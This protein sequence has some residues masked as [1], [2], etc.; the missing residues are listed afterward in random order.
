MCVVSSS[1]T[2]RKYDFTLIGYDTG[3]SCLGNLVTE[4]VSKVY[5]NLF[6]TISWTPGDGPMKIPITLTCY[7][8][9]GPFWSLGSAWRHRGKT[10]TTVYDWHGHADITD[11]SRKNLSLFLEIK[12]KISG[13]KNSSQICYLSY[14]KSWWEPL[15]NSINIRIA[16]ILPQMYSNFGYFQ[17]PFVPFMC[18][19]ELNLESIK[20][21]K[22]NIS[23][24]A[25]SQ[26]RICAKCTLKG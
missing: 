24:P 4:S 8:I 10:L 26:I 11:L 21:S 2:Q 17:F 1:A 22:R 23:K 6:L 15:N 20:C 7:L 18:P 13:Q 12:P 5:M 19:C 16:I 25:I 14:H 9:F 3:S